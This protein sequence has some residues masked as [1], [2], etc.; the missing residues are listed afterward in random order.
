MLKNTF[1]TISL[2]ALA[3]C[4]L[5]SCSAGLPVSKAAKRT[6]FE[7]QKDLVYTPEKW[8]IPLQGDL[9]RPKTSEPTPGVLLIHGGGWTGG[10]KRYQM[11]SIAQR[12]A[13]RGY[14]VFNATYRT[15]PEWQHPAQYQDLVQALKWMEAN[16]GELNLDST[17][18]A[19]FGYSAGGHLALLVG[20]QAESEGIPLRAIVAGGAPTDLTLTSSPLV[21]L[22]LGGDRAAEPARHREASPVAHVTPM[23]PPVFLYHASHDKVVLPT[24]AEMLQRKLASKGVPY[25]FESTAGPG[26]I[27][28]F[29][30]PGRAIGKALSF[31][32]ERLDR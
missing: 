30:F 24:H 25:R 31:L 6:G 32:D 5:T 8:P 18:L 9:Y 16:A 13:K 27:S 29:L 7:V 17:R 21:E 14:L 3:S 23:S 15:T 20:L 26:H 28:G 10:D 11:S 1:P 2:L 4:L 12:L 19:T 22:L